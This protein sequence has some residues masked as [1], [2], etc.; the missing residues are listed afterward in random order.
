MRPE[1]ASLFRA[2]ERKTAERPFVVAQLGQ[3]LDGRIAT[4]TGDSRYIGAAPSLDHLHRI[5]AEVDAVIVGIG[6]VLADDP[7]LNVR[8]C[9]GRNPA[10]IVIDARG[11]VPAAAKC[12]DG[13]DG[14]RRIV[15]RDAAAPGEGLPAGVEVIALATDEH[16]H[17][18]MR[19]LARAWSE[20][21]FDKVLVEGGARIISR[22]IDAG[23]VDRLH[24]MV[25]AMIIGSGQTGLDLAPIDR[26]S[27]ALRPKVEMISLG[28]GDV[29]FDC[30]LTLGQQGG[31]RHE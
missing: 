17:F 21:G 7:Q 8:R 23:I 27:Q 11:K 26:I 19:D 2:F 22:A 15:F 1:I 13:R 18:S 20:L 6:T 24:L 12:L 4:R 10:R 16:G 14:A 9:E 25:S 3:S 31:E 28:E 29:L 5:R 30:D